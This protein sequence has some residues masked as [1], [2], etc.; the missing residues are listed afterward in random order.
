MKPKPPW[1]KQA[2]RETVWWLVLL[3]W[4]AW[5]LVVAVVATYFLL[6]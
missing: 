1:D 3:D 5:L 6:T 4:A 2:E